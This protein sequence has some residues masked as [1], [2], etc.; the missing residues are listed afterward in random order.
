M[1]RRHRL[2]VLLL[3]LGACS[4]PPAPSPVASATQPA[5]ATTRAAASP[6]SIDVERFAREIDAFDTADRATPPAPGGIVFVGS[7]TIRLWSTLVQDFAGLPVI[8]R[9]FGGSTFPE[10]LHYLQRTVVRYHPRT[11]VVYE[12]DK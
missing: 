12:G 5:V 4:H 10:A 11:V 7:S 1:M 9:G 6:A 8:N 3:A 2:T